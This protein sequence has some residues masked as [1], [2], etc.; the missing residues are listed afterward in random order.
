MLFQ[1]AIDD[2]DVQAQELVRTWRSASDAR[3]RHSHQAM[4]GQMREFGA[5][6]KTGNGY[7]IMYPGD[8][9]APASETIH[10]RCVVVT[11]MTKPGETAAQ[12]IA[13]H[14]R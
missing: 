1:Q 6:F 4:N 13:R 3:V 11:R 2:G 9:N 7:S 8:I 12:Y 5:A 14:S 10:C